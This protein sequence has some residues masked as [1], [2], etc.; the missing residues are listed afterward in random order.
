MTNIALLSAP[1]ARENLAK[2]ICI[3]CEE[4]PDHSGDA[5]GNAKRWQDYLPVADAAIASLLADAS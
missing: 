4:N 1:T 3:A 2:V 5:S